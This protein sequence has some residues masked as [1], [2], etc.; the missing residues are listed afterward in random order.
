MELIARNLLLKKLTGLELKNAPISKAVEAVR[1]ADAMETAPR[2]TGTWRMHEKLHVE[3]R[4]EPFAVDWECSLCTWHFD[5]EIRP[6]KWQY[7]PMCGAQMQAVPV[8]GER[9]G[10]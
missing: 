2:K 7:C 5:D 3:W 10:P 1:E 9:F 8:P 4:A 6:Y